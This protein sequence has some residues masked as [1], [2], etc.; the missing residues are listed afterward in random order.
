MSVPNIKMLQMQVDELHG[1]QSGLIRIGTFSSVAT[2]WLPN[3]IQQFQKD[4][5]NID[6]ELLLGD[7]AEIEI[8]LFPA[9]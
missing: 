1:L 8:G 9:G 5:P 7:Y 6:F 4:F 2:H 3:I